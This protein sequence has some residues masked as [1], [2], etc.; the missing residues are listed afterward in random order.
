MSMILWIMNEKFERYFVIGEVGREGDQEIIFMVI[1]GSHL[2]VA[3]A[4]C[5]K[6]TKLNKFQVKFLISAGLKDMLI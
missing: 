1:F 4:R 3:Q 5:A 6:V 2:S